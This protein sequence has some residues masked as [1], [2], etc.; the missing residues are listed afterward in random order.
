MQSSA[1]VKDEKRLVSRKHERNGRGRFSGK[2]VAAMVIKPVTLGPRDTTGALNGGITRCHG[3]GA[4]RD[5][6][7]FQIHQP[8]YG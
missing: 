6:V 8:A 7:E 4:E 5:A 2:N 1:N 3:K